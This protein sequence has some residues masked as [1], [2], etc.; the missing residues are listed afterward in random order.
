MIKTAILLGACFALPSFAQSTTNSPQLTTA[1]K[2][3]SPVLPS[4][5]VYHHFLEWTDAL[6]RDTKRRGITDPY[7]FAQ[8]FS[9]SLGFNNHELDLIR[10]HAKLLGDDLA[11]QDAKATAV[12]TA[13]RQS[14][15]T[16]IQAGQTLPPAPAAIRELDQQKIAMM[17][18]HYVLFRNELGQAQSSKL[19]GYLSREFAPHINVKPLSGSTRKLS[20]AFDKSTTSSFTT[21]I[22]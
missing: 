10:K 1:S 15:L 8:P 6:D 3:Q 7:A 14:A 13:Y 18:H 19:D 20:R 21:A 12:I 4:Y 17:I 11:Q 16:A 2:S 9:R 22:H 5:V